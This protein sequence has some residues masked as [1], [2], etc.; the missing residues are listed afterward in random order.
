MRR[1]VLGF[2]IVFALC[3]SCIPISALETKANVE[4]AVETASDFPNAKASDNLVSTGTVQEDSMNPVGLNSHEMT[5]LWFGDTDVAV[6]LQADYDFS[7]PEDVVSAYFSIREA[8]FTGTINS[9]SAK[10]V[11]I[12]AKVRREMRQRTKGIANYQ[13]ELNLTITDAEVTAKIEEDRVIYNAD[14]TV[15]ID[16]YE[17]TFF[18]YEWLDNSV[19]RTDVSGFGTNHKIM[20]SKSD[21][22]YTIFSDEYDESDLFGICTMS[23]EALM[24]MDDVDEVTPSPKENSTESED[25]E[26][27][28]LFGVSYSYDVNKAVAYADEWTKNGIDSSKVHNSKYYYYNGANCAN[29]VSQCI[30]EGGVP[31]DSV[32]N[33]NSKG[34]SE[35]WRQTHKLLNYLKG[36]LNGTLY[37]TNNHKSDV[38]TG[39]GTF[40]ISTMNPQTLSNSVVEKGM[41]LWM[42]GKVNGTTQKARH[43]VICVGKNGN[44]PLFDG[45]TNDRFH[46]PL[47][48]GSS[49]F[50]YAVKLQSN[51]EACALSINTQ[52]SHTINQGSICDVQGN[53][54]SNHNIKV[55]AGYIDPTTPPD[56]IDGQYCNIDNIGKKTYDIGNSPVNNNFKGA[57]L[58]AGTH[59]LKITAVCSCGHTVTK[60]I[61]IHVNSVNADLGADFYAHIV[62]KSSQT[63]LTEQDDRN[64]A[65]LSPS[66]A[67]NQIWHFERLPDNLYKITSAQSGNAL[68]VA[69]GKTDTAVNVATV[70]YHNDSAQ[71]WGFLS[72]DGAF[73]VSALCTSYV[74][75][76]GG[77]D[78][79][80]YMQQEYRNWCQLFTIQKVDF[81]PNQDLGENFYAHIINKSSQTYLTEQDDRNVVALSPSGGYNQIWHFERLQDNL[82]KITS[83]KSGNA[84]DVAEGKT[85]T[86]VNV[87]TVPYHNDSAQKWGFLSA[88][89]AFVVSALCTS[90]V[91]DAGGGDGNV[92]MQQEYRN[93]CQLFTIQ[94][95]D[96]RPNED[97]GQDFYARIVNKNNGLQLFNQSDRNVTAQ[98]ASN[99]LRQMWRFERLEDN[100]YKIT[101]AYNGASLDVLN[102][103]TDN[104]T[105]LQTMGYA[106][107]SAQIWSVHA[108]DGGYLISAQCTPCVIDTGGDNGNVH[109]WQETR[110]EN[111]I[112]TIQRVN[113]YE[114]ADLGEDFYARIVNKSNGLQLFNQ[115]DNNVTAQPESNAIHQIW[116]FER[117]ENSFYKITSA[118]NGNSLDVLNYGAE[119][120]ANVQAVPYAGNSAQTW[121]VHAVD[122]GYLIGAQCTLCV[123]DTGGSGGGNAYM[124]EEWRNENQLFAIRKIETFKLDINAR[125]D[126]RDSGTLED[127]ATVDIHING[128]SVANDRTDYCESHS[129]GTTYEIRDIRPKD[130]YAYD[131]V[132]DSSSIIGTIGP[133]ETTEVRLAFSK[134]D[135]VGIPE[136]SK[137][138]TFNGSVYRYYSEPVTWYVAKRFCE[139]H[140]GHLVTI[141]SAEENQFVSDLCGDAQ[142]WIG[143]SSSSP[144]R[145]WKWVTDEPFA[146]DA[147]GDGEPNNASGNTEGGENYVESHNG[148]WNDNAGIEK[149]PFVLETEEAYVSV[150]GV[151]LGMNA[152]K[153]ISW[154]S[155][156]TLSVTI[157]PENA[158]NKGLSWTSSD[159]SVATVTNGI[160]IGKKIGSAIITVRTDDGGYVDTCEVTIVEPVTK[161]SLDKNSLLLNVGDSA[162]LIA[163]ISPSDASNKQVRW[164]SADTSVATVKD[165]TVTAISSG[166]TTVSVITE[167]GGK[168]DACVVTV[169]PPDEIMRIG[170]AKQ[171]VSPGA[172]F[173][174]PVLLKNNPGVIGFSFALKYDA[175]KLEYL[176]ATDGDFIG[177]AANISENSNQLGIAYSSASNQNLTGTV[178]VNLTFRAKSEAT[179]TA[180]LSFVIDKAFDDGF[181]AS[182]P[183][184]QE[185]EPVAFTIEDGEISIADFTPG[186]VDGNGK[187]DNNDLILLTRYRARWKITI[188]MDAADVNSNGKVDNEDLIL[189]TRYRARWKV[190]L[191]PGRVS[192]SQ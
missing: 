73:T 37:V 175:E 191:L 15:T 111:Q 130:G 44:T 185:S 14:G 133:L 57:E 34:S 7:T 18:D 16:A 32:W 23:K 107:N 120:G 42:D 4:S 94:E 192:A 179:G 76:A 166:E 181:L 64:V 2:V 35:T 85:D 135:T 139:E 22:G 159:E 6:L 125:L 128:A 5:E 186:D 66:G 92:Y 83:V 176:S 43:V 162:R 100:F 87:A 180:K 103:G 182:N 121:S 75:D 183:E 122:G 164:E 82:Y 116:H 84:L 46:S 25:E 136:A 145:V 91:L 33:A 150:T 127:Y 134:I 24:E 50:N 88:D 163:T 38:L 95:V 115:D 11:P 63:Y 132:C 30:H 29:F 19:T 1:C 40:D 72:T 151:K 3:L 148:R 117:L 39:Q 104:G 124:C 165:G 9:I 65:A 62:N 101:S 143:A 152:L 98:A 170:I 119:S 158:T 110:N 167:D 21:K 69:G 10:S 190:A 189:L 118:R 89:D 77:G 161:V 147:F 93:W 13:E 123:L 149:Q 56:Y 173:T 168:S 174:V 55:V 177:V 172:T 90:Y 80:V 60:W 109:M 99:S 146:Y 58:S 142:I 154:P 26:L 126:G 157:S 68:D 187:V 54:T 140:G 28:T 106:G 27:A 97:M 102:Y 74:L 70:P 12:S 8:D 59:K 137:E 49:G 48:V 141:T 114:N 112:F 45:N 171:T 113:P 138:A 153:L 108:A 31:Q 184:T 156:K 20:L 155:M 160:V 96:F 178:V 71:K 51:T 86:A 78:G 81:R 169:S 53:I 67:Y 41:L 131:G 79:N 52:D 47:S 61:T 36:T 105:N 129:F 144:E 188:N 17:W